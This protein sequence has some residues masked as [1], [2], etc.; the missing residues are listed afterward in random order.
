[1][2]RGNLG[3][4]PPNKRWRPDKIDAMRKELLESGATLRELAEREGVSPQRISQLVGKLNRK[5]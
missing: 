5:N 2:A 1:M 4:E 3:R